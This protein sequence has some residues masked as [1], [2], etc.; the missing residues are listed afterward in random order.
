MCFFS[1]PRYLFF[2]SLIFILSCECCCNCEN[3]NLGILEIPISFPSFLY[4]NRD[5]FSC[6]FIPEGNGD[7]CSFVGEDF[8]AQTWDQAKYT[9]FITVQTCCHKYADDLKGR[10]D[11]QVTKGGND[12]KTRAIF[13]VNVNSPN[14]TPRIPFPITE[15]NTLVEIT[16]YEPCLSCDSPN[17]CPN[18][19]TN[20]PVY[21]T[22]LNVMGQ[23]SQT[24]LVTLPLTVLQYSMTSC[25]GN[26]Q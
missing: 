21:E 3:Y 23:P 7:I 8:R 15:L 11:V 1:K 5:P 19:N 20:R 6:P 24:T 18:Q 2:V 17:P 4:P 16:Y 25:F 9:L 26:C 12:T 22:A 14:C 13:A 10:S